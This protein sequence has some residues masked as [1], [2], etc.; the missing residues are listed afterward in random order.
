MKKTEKQSN[1]NRNKKVSIRVHAIKKKKIRGKIQRNT[2]I[3]E[4][5]EKDQELTKDKAGVC[6]RVYGSSLVSRKSAPR[7]VGEREKRRINR[8]KKKKNSYKLR[9]A[10]AF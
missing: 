6:P 5:N 10:T 8:T 4:E 3:E 2:H 7:Q 9:G 1:R